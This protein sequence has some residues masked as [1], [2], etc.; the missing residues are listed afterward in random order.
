MAASYPSGAARHTVAVSAAG[1]GVARQ[2]R[3]QYHESAETLWRQYAT[4]CEREPAEQCLA[5]LLGQ[6]LEARMIPFVITPVSV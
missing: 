5:D 2:F 4:F 1:S 6:G 3:V